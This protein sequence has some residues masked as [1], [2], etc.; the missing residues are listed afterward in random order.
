MSEDD[1]KGWALD[2]A[3]DPEFK[4]GNPELR[5][6]VKALRLLFGEDPDVASERE[7]CAKIAE[8]FG[9]INVE[10]EEGTIFSVGEEIAARIREG[11]KDE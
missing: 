5:R 3:L 6:K 2:L 7:R 10:D 4:P 8:R 11:V 1:P 9:G